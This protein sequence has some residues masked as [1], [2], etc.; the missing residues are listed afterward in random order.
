MRHFD[1]SQTKEH[2]YRQ[3]T[4]T[5]QLVLYLIY[6]MNGLLMSSHRKPN[7]SCIVFVTKLAK[8]HIFSMKGNNTKSYT[9]VVYRK[10]QICSFYNKYL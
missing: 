1:K 3:I 9:N 2:R 10:S 8:I 5:F 7:N 4:L 6:S